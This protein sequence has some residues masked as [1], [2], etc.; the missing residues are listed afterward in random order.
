MSRPEWAVLGRTWQKLAEHARKFSD[1]GVLQVLPIATPAGHPD[2]DEFDSDMADMARLFAGIQ[3]HVTSGARAE[4]PDDIYEDM[5]S[6]LGPF[7]TTP[8]LHLA[9][10]LARFDYIADDIARI[11]GRPIW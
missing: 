3:F 6:S 2:L 4:V 7:Q 1:L 5:V 8:S 9:I 11:A 10:E